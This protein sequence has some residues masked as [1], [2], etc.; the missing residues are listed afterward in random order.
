MS[1]SVTQK[2]MQIDGIEH[3]FARLLAELTDCRQRRLLSCQGSWSWC[4]QVAQIIQSQSNDLIL[5]SNQTQLGNIVPFAKSETLLGQEAQVVIV[6]LFKGLNADVLCV[7][8]G[9]VRAGGLLILLSPDA[10]HWGQINDEYAIWQ[11][12][13]VSPKLRFIEYVFEKIRADTN[14][15][16]ELKEDR[17]LPVILPLPQASMTSLLDGKTCDQAR[18]LEAIDAWLQHPRQKI[19]LVTANRGRGKSTCLGFMVRKLVQENGLSV[20]VTAYSRQSAAMLLAQFPGAQFVAPDRLIE[21]RE[22]AD[23]LVIDE[24]AMLPYAMLNQLCRQFKR[25]VMA[26]TT[27]GYEG[28]GQGFLIRFI[29]RLPEQEL[30]RLHLHQPVRW[31]RND[32]LENWLDE[33]FILNPGPVTVDMSVSDCRYRVLGGSQNALILT[34]IYHLMVSA[35]YRTRPS[36]LRALMENPDLMAIVAECETE[37]PGV[38]LI[39]HEGGFDE[40]LSQQVFLGQRRPKGHLLAQ[41]LTAQA[42]L[43]DFATYDGLRIQ[44]IAVVESQ[45]RQGIGR[46]LVKTADE[47]A[48]DQNLDYLGASFAFD[49]ESAGFWRSCGFRLVHLGYGQGKSSGNHSVA[50]I[51]VFNPALECK[52]SQLQEKLRNS[53]PLWL[54]QFLQEMDV[55]NVVSLLQ[56]SEFSIELSDIEKNEIRAFSE[57]HKGF[58]LCFVSLQRAIMTSIA[59]TA[60]DQSIHPW[61]IEKLVQN[62]DWNHLSVDPECQ[63][64]KSIQNKLRRLVSEMPQL[65]NSVS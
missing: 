24:A 19:A 7:A 54:C 28:T 8:A 41:M 58:E 42:G 62:R 40:V 44:R 34:R 57:G 20:C 61:V 48:A 1:N 22:T 30:C 13:R 15:C 56:F 37:L 55:D 33:T 43:A 45:R 25:V 47:Y 65:E 63:G 50:V 17:D 52:V 5:I 18:A 59:Q 6:D 60:G 4:M 21:T 46:E 9:L 3:W 14:A 64:R 38:A 31:G 32:C 51:R 49:S 2:K 10:K 35:H 16:I 26:T 36:D 53:L 11:N 12:Q 39:N 27:G 23:V 29:A